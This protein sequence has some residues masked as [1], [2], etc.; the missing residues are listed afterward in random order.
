MQFVSTSQAVSNVNVL[1]DLKKMTVHVPTSMNAKAIL[2]TLMQS[3]SI[4]PV[5][6]NVIATRDTPWLTISVIMSM[7]VPLKMLVKLIVPAS[8]LKAPFHVY[9][10]MA[11]HH[12]LIMTVNAVTSMNAMTLPVAVRICTVSTLPVD[13]SANACLDSQKLPAKDLEM[14]TLNVLILTS[15]QLV[16]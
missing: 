3:V 9:V 10:M 6:S 4:S 13:T 12:V 16:N 11:T 14:V 7:N 15:A 2:A 5:P 1:K 8:I